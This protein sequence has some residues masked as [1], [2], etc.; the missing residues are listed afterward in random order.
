M[1]ELHNAAREAVQRVL[2]QK[3]KEVLELELH[4]KERKVDLLSKS[5]E[6][7]A[8]QVQQLK[9]MIKDAHLR[10]EGDLQRT[11]SSLQD[12]YNSALELL[13]LGAGLAAA[14]QPKAD[15]LAPSQQPSA[16]SFGSASN[17][18]SAG[19][20]TGVHRPSCSRATQQ[21]SQQQQQR[22]ACKCPR[23][24]ACRCYPRAAQ[25]A[26]SAKQTQPSRNPADALDSRFSALGLNVEDLAPAATY[27]STV[28]LVTEPLAVLRDVLNLDGS[29]DREREQQVMRDRLQPAEGSSVATGAT[30]P[31]LAQAQFES[32]LRNAYRSMLLQLQHRYQLER[33]RQEDAHK[34]AMQEQEARH[35]AELREMAAI[36]DAELDKAARQMERQEAACRAEM[37]RLEAELVAAKS[38][39]DTSR[40]QAAAA[41]A[42]AEALQAQLQLQRT[43]HEAELQHV[44]QGSMP[45]GEHDDVVRRLKAEWEQ[46][47]RQR[48][49]DYNAL[50]SE[51]AGLRK[52]LSSV[53]EPTGSSGNS[54]HGPSIVSPAAG[55]FD[56][57]PPPS[58]AVAATAASGDPHTAASAQDRRVALEHHYCHLTEDLR[59]TRE[60]RETQQ[61]RQEQHQHGTRQS[62]HCDQHRAYSHDARPQH[63]WEQQRPEDAVSG[64]PD[65]LLVTGS[66]LRV[67]LNP[68][69]VP[70]E[71]YSS[72]RPISPAGSAGSAELPPPPSASSSRLSA[73]VDAVVQGSSAARRGPDMQY[74]EGNS[75]QMLSTTAFRHVDA[76]LDACAVG[77]GISSGGEDLCALGGNIQGHVLQQQQPPQR[78][79]G[80]QQW[81]DRG[82]GTGSSSKARD[83]GCDGG[84]GSGG[85]GS[86][87]S[88]SPDHHASEIT[89]GRWQPEA[90]PAAPSSDAARWAA[91]ASHQCLRQG[92]SLDVTAVTSVTEAAARRA[93]KQSP[94]TA[95]ARSRREAHATVV[96]TR[97]RSPS[98]SPTSSPRWCSGRPSGSTWRKSGNPAAAVV[99]PRCIRCGLNDATSPG[100]C[101]FHPALLSQP[102]GLRF[103]PEWMTC[104]AAGHTAHTPGCFVRSEHFYEPP[105]LQPQPAA[106]GAGVPAVAQLRFGEPKPADART[107]QP[108][109]AAGDK[110]HA[111]GGESDGVSEGPLALRRD[112][113]STGGGDEG[114]TAAAM[115]LAS[116]LK[117]AA[118]AATIDQSVLRRSSV[119]RP[120]VAGA[121]RALVSAGGGSGGG[122]DSPSPKP[123]TRLPSPM[124]R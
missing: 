97:R 91:A 87:N 3:D 57:Q 18:S 119:T 78:S 4:E 101:R 102:G 29:H 73:L 46:A 45:L 122:S 19:C 107:L 32:R 14:S 80:Q 113:L 104:Q 63:Q 8:A 28:G 9:A 79:Q 23:A 54:C 120:L 49:S 11:V 41:R 34:L 121:A 116:G 83:G 108:R 39:A 99:P 103:T 53:A 89:L 86:G 74:M 17:A 66:G 56:G 115:Q 37:Q 38:A 10:Y 109:I 58:A 30:G 105:G 93:C 44:R 59:Q 61:L 100:C 40:G 52:Q 106:A 16:V 67:R 25:P 96:V 64:V 71:E 69:S 117:A 50:L 84:S 12:Q 36:Q 112:R 75:G 95:A 15:P 42:T 27:G 62:H 60:G 72:S 82:G 55:A 33:E 20:C 22:P 47:L 94:R 35:E 43:T 77:G 48:E 6:H 111:A 90:P 26:W 110:V 7:L 65:V 13:Q 24:A 98:P 88:S 51:L 31:L 85:S 81:H 92:D 68:G 5:N 124:R 76:D 123:R 21:P 1:A 114:T 70:G 2:L 118:V